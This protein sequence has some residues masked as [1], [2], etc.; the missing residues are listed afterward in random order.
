MGNILLASL[1]TVFNCA[2]SAERLKL[3]FRL[4]PRHPKGLPEEDRLL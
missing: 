3:H 2:H 1:K 4:R